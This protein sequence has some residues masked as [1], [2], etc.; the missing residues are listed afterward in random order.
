MSN[1]AP[2]TELRA[3][4]RSSL[5]LPLRLRWRGPLGLRMETTH[6]VDVSR[7]GLLV[8]RREP[9]ELN[10]RVWV[11]F[12]YDPEAGRAVQ[13]ET[14]ARVLRVEADPDGGFRVALHLELRRSSVRLPGQERR[15]SARMTF[16]LP[17]F[18]R[19]EGSP[20]PEES[21]TE[22]I[23]RGGVRFESSRIYAAGEGVRAQIPWD[24]WAAAGEIFGR[25]VRVKCG[26]FTITEPA[27]GSPALSPASGPASIAVRWDHPLKF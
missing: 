21:M 13:P 7:E 17:I 3:H 6:T 25:V 22:D 18:V 16:S 12:P 19:E 8:F 23:S 14:S 20:W 15:N 5:R 27:P 26:P 11:T 2:T 4:P 10:S 1:L 24:Q 9:C